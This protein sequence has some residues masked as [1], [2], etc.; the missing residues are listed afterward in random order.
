MKT[1]RKAKR[2]NEKNDIK[3]KFGKRPKQTCPICHKFTL[4]ASHK[5]K[6]NLHYINEIIC[7][8]CGEVIKTED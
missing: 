7:V 4:F 5:R 2:N 6:E 1:L 8:Q 3:M